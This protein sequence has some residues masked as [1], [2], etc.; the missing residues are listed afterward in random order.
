MI[1]RKAKA[2]NCGMMEAIIKD[3]IMSVR[4]MVKELIIGLT[5]LGLKE[6]GLLMKC[7]EKVSLF[8]QTAGIIKVILGKV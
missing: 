4:S 1:C 6:S 3:R 2:W 8:G 7:T 5:G